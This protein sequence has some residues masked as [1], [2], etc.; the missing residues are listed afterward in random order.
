MPHIPGHKKK[1]GLPIPTQQTAVQE[2]PRADVPPI[3]LPAAAPP[4][5][6]GFVP[7]TVK[8]EGRPVGFIERGGEQFVLPRLEI[9]ELGRRGKLRPGETLAEQ[10]EARKQA[11]AKIRQEEL[12][13]QAGVIPPVTD[14]PMLPTDVL[15]FEQAAKSALA[16]TGTGAAVGAGL[17]GAALATGVGAPLAPFILIGGAIVGFVAGFR[18]NLKTQRA[19]ML[20]G[21]AANV[22]KQEQ[23]MLK[24]VMDVNRGGDPARNL[25]F[26]N[27]QLSLVSENY[28]RLH[29]KSNDELSLW[30]GEDGH[31]QLERYELFYS[32]GG[33]RDILTSQM[34][35]AIRNPNL[36]A[37][38]QLESWL[39]EE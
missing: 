29:L 33:M 20:S 14:I 12:A 13:R 31:T 24:L 8:Q 2:L 16:S 37:N 35:D 11:E 19:D 28:A 21:E 34:G 26:F 36:L 23:N 9:E 27:S 17:A 25:E 1:K 18:A 30:L 4:A 7:T 3:Q 39:T 38:V 10:A 32:T 6:G 5:A 15:S 22:R